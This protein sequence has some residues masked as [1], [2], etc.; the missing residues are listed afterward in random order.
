MRDVLGLC[1]KRERGSDSDDGA[2][3]LPD[4]KFV[5]RINRVSGWVPMRSM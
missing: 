2:D 4:K 5:D 3:S 1:E